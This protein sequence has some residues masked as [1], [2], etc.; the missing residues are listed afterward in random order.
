MPL[1]AQ[2]C[3][4]YDYVLCNACNSVKS[5]SSH[6]THS[7]VEFHIQLSPIRFHKC[8]CEVKRQ[9]PTSI[10]TK[11]IQIDEKITGLNYT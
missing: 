3:R 7:L 11:R 4:K 5:K 8:K 6:F 10:R 1:K 2:N 9:I